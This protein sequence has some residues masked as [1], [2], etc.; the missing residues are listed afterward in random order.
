MPGIEEIRQF[1]KNVTLMGNEPHIASQRGEP[2]E[3]PKEPEQGLSED[4]ES[5]LDDT[6]AEDEQDDGNDALSALLQ[7]TG[8]DDEAADDADSA[9]ED[10]DPFAGIDLGD[11]TDGDTD[12]ADTDEADTDAGVD[13]FD[14]GDLDEIEPA[15]EADADTDAD[16]F[17]MPDTDFGDD[18]DI[19]EAGVEAFDDLEQFEPPPD[20]FE[21]GEDEPAEEPEEPE[22]DDL[23]FLEDD[24][25]TRVDPPSGPVDVEPLD[26]DDDLAAELSGATAADANTDE[27][28]FSF[29]FEEDEPFELELEEEGDEAAADVEDAEPVDD[30]ISFDLPDSDEIEELE[31]EG[32][33]DEADDDFGGG[34]EEFDV[35]DFG[36][37]GME[38]DDAAEAG[39]FDDPTAEDADDE[40]ADV[41]EF[42]LGDFG[43][44][45]GVIEEEDG[46]YFAD[47]EELNPAAALPTQAPRTAR[48]FSDSD[49]DDAPIVLSDRDFE[50][51]KQTLDSLP[52]NL[53]I[54]SEEII[55]DEDREPAEI[56][57]LIRALIK[58]SSPK[59]IARIAGGIKG[60]RIR[61]PSNYQVRRGVV[62]EEEK[63]TFA[64]QFRHRILPLVRTVALVAL[65]LGVVT[66]LG[67]RFVYQPLYARYLYQQGLTEIDDNRYDVGEELFDRARDLHEHRVWYLRYA[68]AFIERRQY[69][70]AIQ[71]LNELVGSDR[72]F[73]D[74]EGLLTLASL[75]SQTLGDFS[76]ANETLEYYIE[77]HGAE[78]DALL[79]QGDNY[80]RWADAD[81]SP[82]RFE[83]A[84][85]T[86]SLMAQLYGQ[87]DE[88]LERLLWYHVRAGNPDPVLEL[89]GFFEDANPEAPV[90]PEIYAEAAGFLIDRDEIAYP[91]DML[92]R[93]LRTD[94]R[95]PDAYYQFGRFFR[96]MGEAGNELE[97]LRNARGLF[98][99]QDLTTARER[100]MNIDTHT[101]LAE[102][103]LREGRVLQAEQDYSTA[104]EM[105][106]TENAAG[107]LRPDHRYGRMFAGFGDLFFDQTGEYESAEAQ[108]RLALGNRYG[109]GPGH[110]PERI[111]Y[112]LGWIAFRDD[113][114]REA[115]DRFESIPGSTRNPN[116]AFARAN[117]HYFRN[118]YVT[119][120]SYLE[121]VLEMIEAE[122][123]SYGNDFNVNRE[124]E[125]RELV[126]FRT[127]ASN[128]LGVVMH[129]LYEQS[130]DRNDR[131][132]ALVSLTNATQDATDLGRDPQTAERSNSTDLAFLNQR[133]VLFP[134][135]DFDLRIYRSLPRDLADRD[136]FPARL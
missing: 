21:P 33:L 42:S 64:Y 17:D 84:F 47:E 54:A 69:E 38:D 74:R 35:G 104:V 15:P 45:F 94:P 51:V 32:D 4:L 118:Q 122:R 100:A 102:Y 30:D 75:Q 6:P 65:L 103:H 83:N 114:Y 26:D 105:F 16:E 53:R 113:R 25:L 121:D 120:Q 117:T 134:D 93:V 40:I 37:F 73:G 50:H 127:M 125:H 87:L 107:L 108:Y 82:E 18:A 1:N 3:D 90:T 96:R 34:D 60:E 14:L 20:E 61:L 7:D 98:A 123:Q 85:Q 46:A 59:D 13:E 11:D 86:Y 80:L 124:P 71:K 92:R 133:Y 56:R 110:D 88:I 27:D 22:E 129:R 116:L 68:D 57:P 76:G 31:V 2:L 8:D 78:Y 132:D 119:A 63:A 70:R 41:N 72:Y 136:F 44:E 89:V 126:Q 106:T 135:Q 81:P 66:W 48:Q 79:A 62:F 109:E 12:E 130:G 19:E 115:L 39:E 5:L 43:Q 97:S 52:L 128:N 67:V 91:R 112:R 28:D 23:S 131:A 36:E 101:L 95:S 9:L 10:D 77:Q 111:V 49:D 24:D 29:G 99:E 58:G 55:A